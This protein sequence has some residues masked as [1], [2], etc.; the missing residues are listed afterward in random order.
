MHNEL[1]IFSL[2]VN[3]L[4][5][6]VVTLGIQSPVKRPGGRSGPVVDLDCQPAVCQLSGRQKYLDTP[7]AH[8]VL[9]FGSLWNIASHIFGG[10]CV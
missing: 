6:S 4:N 1:L 10:Y 8:A 7:G 2:N 3:E 5:V 9:Q